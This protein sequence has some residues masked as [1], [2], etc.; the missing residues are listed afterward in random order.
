[1]PVAAGNYSQQGYRVTVNS[2]INDPLLVRARMLDISRN[3]FMMESIL[4]NAG[5]NNSG[6]VEYEEAG[7]LYADSDPLL[8]AEGAEIPLLTGQDGIM[9]AAFTAKYGAGIEITQETKDRNKVSQVE[10][11]MKQVRNSFIRLWERKM[12]TALN[13]ASTLTLNRSAIWSNSATNIRSD[14]LTAI[15]LVREASIS[16]ATPG[17][18]VDDYLGFEPDTLVMSTRTEA[19]FFN[20]TSVTDVYKNNGS[21]TLGD[22]QPMY[23]GT[24]ERDFM[25]LTVMRSRF[26]ADDIVWILQRNEVG[27]YSDERPFQVSPL[28]RD[29]PRE[30]W[31]ADAVRRTAIFIDQP[32]AACKITNINA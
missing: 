28:Y 6:V 27:G 11:R 13:T 10:R 14:V 9:R 25:G 32:K 8:V 23:T 1:M 19:L 21:S 12:F 20:N 29:N 24:L 17:P 31:R 18:N 7:P 15:R 5:G 26:M 22:K 30:V 2:Y 3:E 16:G 4:R